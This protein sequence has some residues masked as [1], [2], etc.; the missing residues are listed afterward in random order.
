M[1]S[2]LLLGRRGTGCKPNADDSRDLNIDKLGLASS[3]LPAE[4]DYWSIVSKHVRNQDYSNSCVGQT[5]AEQCQITHFLTTGEWLDLSALFP[6][7][8]GRFVQN[9][10]SR[11]GITDTGVNIRD[12]LKAVRHIGICGEREWA[13]SLSRVNK[14]PGP[15]AYMTADDR[16]GGEFHRVYGTG[17]VKPD[18]IKATLAARL[19]PIAAF[20]VDKSFCQNNGPKVIDTPAAPYAW[21]AMPFIGYKYDADFGPVYRILNHYS[22][23]WR[24]GG[25]AWV[26]EDYV[27][28]ALITDITI[29]HGWE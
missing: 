20:N 15:E 16:A 1:L 26:T 13:F 28:S 3:G 29:Y 5:V 18:A 8:Y 21:H 24:D 17:T 22:N 27:R 19:I 25:S 4:I 12:T 7:Y 2:N 6:Y 23:N 10:Y 14:Q 9:G 11:K